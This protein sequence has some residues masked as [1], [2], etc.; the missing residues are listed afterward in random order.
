MAA[1]PRHHLRLA[2]TGIGLALLLALG[3]L[4][5]QGVEA[6]RSRRALEDERAM[7]RAARL[8][9]RART[10]PEVMARVPATLGFELD[11][12]GIEVDPAL[13]WLWPREEPATRDLVLEDRLARLTEA[14]YGGTSP[15]ELAAQYDELLDAP[16]G[17]RAR[18]VVLTDAAWHAKRAGLTERLGSLVSRLGEAFAKISPPDLADPEV[19]R[20]V[21]AALRLDAL[22]TLELG[23]RLGLFIDSALLAGSDAGTNAWRPEQVRRD[24]RRTA[25]RGADRAWRALGPEAA[26]ARLETGGVTGADPEGRFLWWLPS[27]EG[28]TRAAWLDASEFVDAVRAASAEG[29]GGEW[30]E[31]V[32]VSFDSTSEATGIADI[33]GIGSVTL[34]GAGDEGAIGLG[35]LPAIF[36]VVLFVVFV[37]VVVQEL[38]ASRREAVAV[39]AH[40][41]FVTNVTHE[42]RTP[43]ASI[44]LLAE[45]LAEGLAPHRRKD[46]ER[47]LLAESTRLSML[48][49][50]VLDLG[51]TERGARALEVEP[52]PVAA[53]VEETAALLRPLL[54]A[55]GREMTVQVDEKATALA[56]RSS[57]TQALVAVLDNARKYGA[58]P[59][60][61]EVER[62][63][64]GV[65]IQIHDE[66]PGVPAAEREAVFERFSRGS[67]HRDGS[68]PGLGIGLYLARTLVRRMG[69]ELRCVD[70][71][72]RAGA[73]FVFTLA[74]ALAP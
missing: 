40:R 43:L 56:D 7:A 23:A 60:G 41:D 8:L 51:R 74:P 18:L 17:P 32:T 58:G 28:A 70:P 4:I 30:P 46:H 1:A 69:G 19:S 66:G 27:D 9:E 35:G 2:L 39:A 38:R 6:E 11:A 72:G 73:R 71:G 33:P 3:L 62:G 54:E 63:P 13:G 53:L 25:A 16:I 22:A 26:A 67:H 47:M 64:H 34:S 29:W 49:E 24:D 31:R 10:S 14:E 48:I 20:A 57:L 45:M 15:A 44:R 68:L 50:N 59:I 21:A 37:L 52:T 5:A 65:S 55:D 36:T 61:V 12:S 42:L